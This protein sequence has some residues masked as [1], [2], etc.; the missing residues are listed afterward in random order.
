MGL[1]VDGPDINQSHWRYYGVKDTVVVGLMAIKGLSHSGAEAIVAEREQGG[2]YGSLSDSAGRVKLGRN[3][4]IAL[5]PA[6]AFDS[7][8]QDIER[9]LQAREL[10]QANTK[11]AWWG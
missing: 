8:A 5:C 1:V 7:I 9:T 3:D 11:A 10:L 6:R 2:V 4:L